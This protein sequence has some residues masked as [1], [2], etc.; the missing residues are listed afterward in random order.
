MG[1]PGGLGAIWGISTSKGV[2]GKFQGVSRVFY[3]V[4]EGVTN[5]QGIP[6]ELR[7]VSGGLR[8]FHGG[9]RGR[10]RYF[11]LKTSP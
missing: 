7:R 8:R 3:G 4:L 10:L 1:V 2:L 9:S 11:I 6:K 5:S